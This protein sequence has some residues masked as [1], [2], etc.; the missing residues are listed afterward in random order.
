MNV[1]G[2]YD[3]VYKRAYDTTN[4][5]I[6]SMVVPEGME[7]ATCVDVSNV[8]AWSL[9]QKDHEKFISM[10]PPRLPFPSLWFEYPILIANDPHTPTVQNKGLIG[11]LAQETG[12][13][14]QPVGIITF[15]IFFY[16]QSDDYCALSAMGAYNSDRKELRRFPQYICPEFGNS[17]F[18]KR[19]ETTDFQWEHAMRVIIPSL[20]FFNCRNVELRRIERSKKSLK[21]YARKLIKPP[22]FHVIEIHK[23]TVR[24]VY[25][26][27]ISS[28]GIVRHATMVRGHFK[29]YTEDNKLFGQKIGTWF[30][31]SHARGDIGTP[32]IRDYKVYEPRHK[33]DCIQ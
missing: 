16:D 21:S 13:E 31:E 8:A 19:E 33:G 1:R 18:E 29:T 26:G 22:E 2:L 23:Q 12:L 11:V 3:R 27:G 30:W 24:N 7:Q 28:A 32:T 5:K 25:E 15:S 17:H 9:E 6:K 20:V 10:C 4:D 14:D